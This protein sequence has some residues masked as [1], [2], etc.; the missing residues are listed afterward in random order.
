MTSDPLQILIRTTLCLLSVI[1]IYF[2]WSDIEK[3]EHIKSSPIN[4]EEY[5]PLSSNELEVKLIGNQT[6]PDSSE[7]D[8]IVKRPLFNDD[9]LPFVYVAPEKSDKK[10]KKIPEK[11]VAQFR[12]NA[13][14][15]TPEKQIAI[16]QSSKNKEMNRISLGESIDDWELSEVTNHSVQLKKGS[17]IKTLEL[18]IKTSVKKPAATKKSNEKSGL[19]NKNAKTQAKTNLKENVPQAT[20]DAINKKK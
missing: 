5:L 10:N 9:R 4:T 8:E 19:T 18:E 1:F 13:V 11:P 12:L 20:K 6:I 17:Q 2:I 7:F 15:I 14:V 3:I 16:I